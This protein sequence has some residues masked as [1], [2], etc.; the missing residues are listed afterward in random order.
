[1]RVIWAT[2]VHLNFLDDDEIDRFYDRMADSDASAV[3]LGGDIGEASS[4]EGYLRRCEA[5]VRCP[6]YF[7]LGNHDYYGGYV[8][9]VRS[10][11][12]ALESEW[13]RWLPHCGVIRLAPETSLVGHGGW[14]DARLGD[15]E[16]SSVVLSDFVLIGELREAVPG[17]D[18]LAVLENKPALR[19]ILNQ[20]GDE[21]AAAVTP[22]LAEAAGKSKRVLFLTHVPPFKA[23]CWHQG[24]VSGDDWLPLFACGAVG[25]AVSEVADANPSCA[26]TVLCG[27][28]HGSG[29]ARI[30]PN[31]TV[32]TMASSYGTPDY[33]E[34]DLDEPDFGLS[35]RDWV[36]RGSQD[37]MAG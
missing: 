28:T 13:L 23:A 2:D 20:L 11:I 21:A 9:V 32:F 25:R 18:P 30:S 4:V 17:D 26:I 19:A 27:H 10:R 3:L 5:R 12:R 1:M 14:G 29:H 16:A 24:Q 36:D 34:L 8:R 6:I 35:E 31:L 7:V 22:S 15:F 37:W 33:V